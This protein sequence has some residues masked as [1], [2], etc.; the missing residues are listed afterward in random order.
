MQTGANKLD[1]DFQ[2]ELLR[3]I[4]NQNDQKLPRIAPVRLK[5]GLNFSNPNFVDSRVE[6]QEVM[7]QNRV[8]TD[9]T[10]T[11][12]YSVLNASLS[13]DVSINKKKVSLF[14]QGR[15]LTNSTIREHVSFLKDIAPQPGRS[16][17][18]GITFKF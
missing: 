12:G 5:F 2:P 18:L 16:G 1:F 8:S 15:N 9:E 4:D 6:L 10:P 17:I 13:K 3:G 14:L 11:N 7:K